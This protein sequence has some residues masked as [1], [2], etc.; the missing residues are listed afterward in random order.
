[1]V[2]AFVTNT[3]Y[4][5]GVSA[6][7]PLAWSVRLAGRYMGPTAQGVLDLGHCQVGPARGGRQWRPPCKDVLSLY[8]YLRLCQPCASSDHVQHLKH[9][10]HVQHLSR[11]NRV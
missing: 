9:L 4:R 3:A 5:V 7:F 10:N 1:M 11:A 8:G 2:R 6:I